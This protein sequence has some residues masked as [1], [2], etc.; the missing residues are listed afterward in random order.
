MCRITTWNMEGA[1]HKGDN[2]WTDLVPSFFKSDE[3][4]GDFACLQEAGPVPAS[5]V[6]IAASA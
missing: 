5:A 1:T 6:A 3:V 4:N 2:K